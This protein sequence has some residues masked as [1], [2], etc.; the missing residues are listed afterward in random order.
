[1]VIH[2]QE[3]NVLLNLNLIGTSDCTSVI[4]ITN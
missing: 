4:Q 1:M 2:A 3:T